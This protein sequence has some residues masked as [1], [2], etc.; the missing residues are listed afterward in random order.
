MHKQAVFL[1]ILLVSLVSISFA[2]DL[3]GRWIGKIGNDDLGLGLKVEGKN[4]SGTIYTPYGAG[5]ISN[6]K[7]KGNTF[8]F[9]YAD[10]GVVIA[11]T[12][13]F[14]GDKMDLS[15]RMSE[16]EITGALTRMKDGEELRITRRMRPEMTEYWEPVPKIVDPGPYPDMVKAPSDAIVLF[17]GRDL[18]AWKSRDGSEAK[19]KVDDGVITV[20]KG[21]G[22]ISTRKK[23]GD[24]QLHIE[25]KVPDRYPGA[26]SIPRKQR[27]VAAGSEHRS[28]STGIL[29]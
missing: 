4:L 20:A 26:E 24:Y 29:V 2:A 1:P 19:W 16:R 28:K 18:S 17:D 3:N 6:G 12:G 14:E 9:T 5:P 25:W 15:K 27:R 22:D 13:K 7:I 23:F 10:N 11:Y 8:S 21:T